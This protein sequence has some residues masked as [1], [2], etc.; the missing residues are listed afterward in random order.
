MAENHYYTCDICGEKSPATS[1]RYSLG[2]TMPEEWRR[3]TVRHPDRT[4]DVIF[5]GTYRAADCCSEDCLRKALERYLD[6]TPAG[7]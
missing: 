3:F 5:K 7:K 6:G 1:G 4:K 2:D